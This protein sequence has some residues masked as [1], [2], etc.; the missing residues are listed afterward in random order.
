MADRN[1]RQAPHKA[2]GLGRHPRTLGALAGVVGS[3]EGDIGTDIHTDMNID[4]DIDIDVE[5]DVDIDIDRWAL[6]F[7]R[8]HFLSKPRNG[9]QFVSRMPLP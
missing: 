4:M 5:V 3:F 2:L 6:E 7:L 9:G 8:E 1:L